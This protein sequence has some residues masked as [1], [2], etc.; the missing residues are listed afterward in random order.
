MWNDKLR[1]EKDPIAG[2]AALVEKWRSDMASPIAAAQCGM[3]DDVI[4]PD[5]LRARLIA[6]FDTLSSR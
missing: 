6:A 4:M 3:I 5:E 1:G 2:R